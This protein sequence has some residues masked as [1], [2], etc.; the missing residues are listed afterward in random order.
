[1]KGES[2]N[3]YTSQVFLKIEFKILIYWFPLLNN[4]LKF[5]VELEDVGGVHH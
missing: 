2:G 1:M 4:E 5:F 3:Q